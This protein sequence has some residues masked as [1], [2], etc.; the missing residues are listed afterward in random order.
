MT[1]KPLIEND[2]PAYYYIYVHKTLVYIK[3]DQMQHDL[4]IVNSFLKNL[5]ETKES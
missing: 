2:V 1:V 3:K 4:S 5:E